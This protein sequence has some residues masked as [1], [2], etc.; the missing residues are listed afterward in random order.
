MGFVVILDQYKALTHT[1]SA[2]Q[3]PASEAKKNQPDPTRLDS[4]PKSSR[5]QV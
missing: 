2:I 1:K 4:N 5:V 3:R